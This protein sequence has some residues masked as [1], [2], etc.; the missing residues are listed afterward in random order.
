MS[1]DNNT[2]YGLARFSWSDFDRLP[3]RLR[4][5][6]NYSVF[7]MGTDF[8]VGQLNE[9]ANP[10]DLAVELEHIDAVNARRLALE[11]Y[12]PRYPAPLAAGARAARI[13]PCAVA[14]AR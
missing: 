1:G 8:I 3:A 9:G 12:G 13:G 10:V 11:A 6:L 2:V 7:D 14:A 5:V 4:Q